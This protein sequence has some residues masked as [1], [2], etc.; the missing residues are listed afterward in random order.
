MA[1]R[2]IAGKGSIV[3]SGAALLQ[4][5]SCGAEPEALRRVIRIRAGQLPAI[6]RDAIRQMQVRVLL[7]WRYAKEA[8]ALAGRIRDPLLGLELR[9][10]LAYQ[11]GD[12]EA[13]QQ[14]LQHMQQNH[15]LKRKQS[16]YLCRFQALQLDE[17]R[18]I[19]LLSCVT[20]S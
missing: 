15:Q 2:L 12:L 10:E 7:D 4:A 14:Q 8:W 13:L 17:Y 20:P 16:W 19:Y 1:D 3:E 18:K 11:L 5:V 6:S 9:L